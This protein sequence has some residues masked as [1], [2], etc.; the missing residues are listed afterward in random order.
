MHDYWEYHLPVNPPGAYRAE[1]DVM[2]T[3]S[4]IRNWEGEGGPEFQ[5]RLRDNVQNVQRGPVAA[6]DDDAPELDVEY[7]CD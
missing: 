4:D 3:E 7:D 5:P 1:G 2:M 6:N